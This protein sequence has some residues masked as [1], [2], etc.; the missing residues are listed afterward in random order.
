MVTL[1]IVLY[2]MC[3]IGPLTYQRNVHVDLPVYKMYPC[4]NTNIEGCIRHSIQLYYDYILYFVLLLV[5]IVN[6]RS[7]SLGR[8]D[9]L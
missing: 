1:V 2:L 6:C 8:I 3:V 4:M 9:L 7:L 5:S